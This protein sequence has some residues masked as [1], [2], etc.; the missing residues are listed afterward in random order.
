MSGHT[1]FNGFTP[2]GGIPSSFMNRANQDSPVSKE[3]PIDEV[4]KIKIMDD[5]K[6]SLQ[7]NIVYS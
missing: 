1:N 2:G 5:N 3:E 6:K 4:D 7:N